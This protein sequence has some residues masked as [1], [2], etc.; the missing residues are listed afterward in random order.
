MISISFPNSDREFEAL[1]V[2]VAARIDLE[3]RFPAWPF[4]G[5]PGYPVIFEF[6]RMLGG[7]FGAV[8]ASLSDTYNDDEITV[9]GLEPPYAYYREEYDH[10]PGFRLKRARPSGP[11][12][13]PQCGTRL[14][15]IQPVRSST[16]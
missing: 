10:F 7:D 11:V 8:L 9:L 2:A 3:S 4:R 13:E 5:V 14:T 6:D 16:L 12:M 15:M 1:R